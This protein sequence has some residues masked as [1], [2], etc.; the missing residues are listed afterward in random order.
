MIKTKINRHDLEYFLFAMVRAF[1]KEA[2][3]I[4]PDTS[5]K[6]LAPDDE[7]DDEDVLA[8]EL[9]EENKTL[10]VEIKKGKYLKEDYYRLY[11]ISAPFTKENEEPDIEKEQFFKDEVRGYIY[12]SFCE[13]S[14]I[15]LPWGNLTGIRPTKLYLSKLMEFQKEKNGEI[16][17]FDED[18]VEKTISNMSDIFRVDRNKGELGTGIA[19]R[20][21][22]IMN[23]LHGKDGYSVYIG[24]PFCP[25]TCLYCSF[26]SNPVFSFKDKIATYLDCVKKELEATAELMKDYTLDTIY[27]GGGTPTS[28][29]AEELDV[30]LNCVV[31]TLPMDTVREFT[32]EAGRPDSITREKLECL[33]RYPVTRISINP[34]TMS[35][36]TLKYIGRNHSVS[37][38]LDAFKM[39]R[40]LGFDNINTDIILGL[41]EETVDDVKN[42]IDE[43]KK[44]NPESLTVHSLAIK[45][46][47]RLKMWMDK[48]GMSDLRSTFDFDEAMNI[49]NQGARAM[50]MN[51]YYMYRQKDMGGN[52][53]NTGFAREGKYGLYNI[54]MMEEVQSIVAC[55]AG[56]VTKRVFEDGHIER[57]DTIKDV[58]LYISKIDEMIERKQKL[59]WT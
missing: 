3:V 46:A 43:I 51:A 37:Q 10:S 59:F 14:G 42:T 8:C 35:D 45:R 55:G 22:G 40:E 47:S 12:D 21:Q 44:L 54:L 19:I 58:D 57:C 56:T 29:S 11:N 20:E 17:P 25:S 16:W 50:D 41:P 53:E 1:F 28:I 26:T 9:I 33:K 4:P 36:K 5:A 38:F 52:L 13:C 48:N 2:E 31:T 34:Q 49:A 39:A 30:L 7:G 23:S 15:T 6:N 18:I 24:I 27:I 32:V